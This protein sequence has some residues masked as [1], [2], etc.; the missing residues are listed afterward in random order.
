MGGYGLNQ[1]PGVH[2]G[3]GYGS[4]GNPGA[5]AS[6]ATTEPFA[7]VS[8]IMAAVSI[9]TGWCCPIFFIVFGAV[10]VVCSIVSLNRIG[11]EPERYTGKGLAWAG[12]WITVGA[13]LLG[14]LMIFLNI[15]MSAL[16]SGF[17]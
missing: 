13:I 17:P 15:G 11:N 16:S 1:P 6:G 8:I 14:I 12:I 4:P 7:I 2:A 9:F 10:A 5:G 3:Y